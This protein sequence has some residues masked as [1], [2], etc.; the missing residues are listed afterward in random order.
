MKRIVNAL[1]KLNREKNMTNINRPRPFSLTLLAASLALP[2]M[3]Q[4][5]KPTLTEFDAPGAG[6]ISSP[7]CAPECGTFAFANNALGDQ[8]LPTFAFR[9][10]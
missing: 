7:A 4:L 10:L 1:R 5:H 2:A 9:S 8:T 6:T 3:A